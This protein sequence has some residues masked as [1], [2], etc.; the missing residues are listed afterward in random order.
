[1]NEVYNGPMERLI[2]TT[3]YLL[4]LVSSVFL[5]TNALG[6]LGVK[7]IND[8]IQPV[9]TFLAKNEFKFI[10]TYRYL[11]FTVGLLLLLWTQTKSLFI[12]IFFT[13]IG[14]GT[15]LT[16]TSLNPAVGI[17]PFVKTLNIKFLVDFAN[18]KVWVPLLL[19]VASLFPV[20]LVLAYREPRAASASLT[21]SGLLIVIIGVVGLGLAAIA[22]KGLLNAP[23]FKTIFE[24]V[25]SLG[26]LTTALGSVIG[27]LALFRK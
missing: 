2:R 3:G 21:S 12:K 8:F 6:T 17:L 16:L 23:L 20:Y 11:G 1:M 24:Y 15:I 9:T 13:I 27:V 22:T 26:Y 25:I 4:L 19:L 7:T 5:L 18:L 14:V 10:N